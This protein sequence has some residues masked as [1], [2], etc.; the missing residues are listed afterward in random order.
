VKP[1]C[2]AEIYQHFGG[3]CCL[4][5][6]G[7]RSSPSWILKLLSSGVWRNVAWQEDTVVSEASAVSIFRL[8]LPPWESQISQNVAWQKKFGEENRRLRSVNS[9][10]ISVKFGKWPKQMFSVRVVATFYSHSLLGLR[11]HWKLPLVSN[12]LKRVPWA[13]K[14]TC[15]TIHYIATA[16][17]PPVGR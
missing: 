8:R 7:Q 10:S 9:S 4:H 15:G 6:H 3:T 13:R 17:F 2:L 12:D 16:S 11:V 5:L 1:C 14:L